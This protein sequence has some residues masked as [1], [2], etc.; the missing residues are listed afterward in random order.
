MM[1]RFQTDKR[2]WIWASLCLFVLFWVVP[3]PV[4]E[5]G[6][7]SYAEQLWPVL[8][9]C[10]HKEVPGFD[11]GQSPVSTLAVCSIVV[12]LS[13]IAALVVGWL[14]QGLVVILRTAKQGERTTP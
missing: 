2:L 12:C 9:L 1:T 13:A 4:T 8:P 14:L 11:K 3:F 6:R 5:N 10:L 7:E